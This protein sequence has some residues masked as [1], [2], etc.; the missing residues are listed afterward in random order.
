MNPPARNDI[1]QTLT[2][3]RERFP[4]VTADFD[5]T[6]LNVT[7][8]GGS[9]T[10]TLDGNWLLGRAGAFDAACTWGVTEAVATVTGGRALTAADD[11][12]G[13]TP[14]LLA[15]GFV[16]DEV[17]L[18]HDAYGPHL[19]Q[20]RA[21]RGQDVLWFLAV[22]DEPQL[23]SPYTETVLAYR[24][25]CAAV[26]IRHQEHTVYDYEQLAMT[27]DEERALA[28]RNPGV[29]VPDSLCAYGFRPRPGVFGAL[30]AHFRAGEFGSVPA[31][32][33][34]SEFWRDRA[35]LA[36]PLEHTRVTREMARADPSLRRAWEP[37]TPVEL[38]REQA[39]RMVDELPF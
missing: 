4:D 1:E 27:E 12:H 21:R 37:R 11:H 34:G 17:C 38:P 28:K 5:G 29:A 36:S 10:F 32:C 30:L 31:G 9:E 16:V 33:S 3:A 19:T 18:R 2:R 7:G 14:A 24:K 35:F 13:L 8:P 15:E 22:Y 6:H 20:V 25:V 39:E 23:D 26:A